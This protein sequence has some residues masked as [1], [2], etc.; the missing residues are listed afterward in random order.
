M[1]YSFIIILWCGLK[2]NNLLFLSHIGHNSSHH[3]TLVISRPKGVHVTHN[4]S[5]RWFP[6][7]MPTGSGYIYRSPG[8]HH[9]LVVPVLVGRRG[10]QSVFTRRCSI[11]GNYTNLLYNAT[12]ICLKAWLRELRRRTA[13]D[14]LK[15]LGPSISFGAIH[16]VPRRWYRWKAQVNFL[17]GPR[18]G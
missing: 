11:L 8:R 2:L 14:F 17:F 6:C 10:N 18:Y 12:A 4:A 16:I 3:T 9:A 13:R 7:S 1:L 15:D 5:L